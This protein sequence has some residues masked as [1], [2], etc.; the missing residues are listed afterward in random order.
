MIG[1]LAIES[2]LNIS[3]IKGS[4]FCFDLQHERLASKLMIFK[5]LK[6][7]FAVIL[8]TSVKLLILSVIGYSFKDTRRMISH[9]LTGHF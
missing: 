1:F 6:M 4:Y 3:I 7:T 2:G 9:E 8:I 5:V